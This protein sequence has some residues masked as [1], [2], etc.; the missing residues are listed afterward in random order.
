VAAKKIFPVLMDEQ[1]MAEFK[2]LAKSYG[3]PLASLIRRLL[4][5][6]LKRNK[7]VDSVSACD[8]QVNDVE[9]L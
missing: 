4:V 6:E 9:G 5:L 7:F 1:E 2:Q 3:L 8:C